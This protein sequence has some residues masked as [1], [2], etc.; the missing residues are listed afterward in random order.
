MEKYELEKYDLIK[1]KNG[2]RHK[3]CELQETAPKTWT[4]S[5]EYDEMPVYGLDDTEVA[6]RLGEYLNSY[7]TSISSFT[8]G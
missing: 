3:V 7:L 5:A 1:I 2:K 6:E 8:R 4:F